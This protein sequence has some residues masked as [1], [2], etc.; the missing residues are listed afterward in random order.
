MMPRPKIL[1][2]NR[3]R[4]YRACDYCK[5][6]K[7][8]CDSKTPCGNC[9]KRGRDIE[10]T[11]PASTATGRGARG[12]AGRESR[13]T[14]PA[15]PLTLLSP[16]SD[17]RIWELPQG[18]VSSPCSVAGSCSGGQGSTSS[19][20]AIPPTTSRSNHSA[21]SIAADAEEV[22]R[23]VNQESPQEHFITTSSKEKENRSVY[24]GE[25]TSLSFLAF[26]RH[27][28]KPLIGATPFTDNEQKHLILDSDNRDTSG[29]EPRADPEEEASLFQ[30]YLEVTSGTLHLFSATEI[31]SLLAGVANNSSDCHVEDLAAMDAALA[32][33]AQARSGGR[34]DWELATTYFNRA[35]KVGFEDMLANPSLS[36]VRLF[37]LLAFFSLGA[38]RQNAASIYL[39]IASKSA[40][41]LGLHQPMSWKEPEKN[42]GPGF[43]MRVWHSLCILDVLISSVLGRPC[44]VPRATRHTIQSLPLH[45]DQPAFNVMLRGVA[46][47]DDICCAIN[48]GVMIDIATAQDLLRKLQAWCRDIP[49]SLRRF[50]HR[51][52]SPLSNA[53]RRN[54]FS[55]IYMSGMYYFAVI[56]V[57]RPFL[58]ENFMARIRHRPHAV[59]QANSDPAR[60]S[61]VQVCMSSASYMG[62]LS[63]QLLSIAVASA[64]PLGSLSLF[65]AW[66]FGAA[67]IL[68]F[69]ICAGET[70]TDLNE[71]F[72]GVLQLLTKIGEASPQ[73]KMYSETL[74]TFAESISIYQRLAAHKSRR[75]AEQLLEQVLVIDLDREPLWSSGLASDLPAPLPSWDY[76][77]AG[78]DFPMMEY[79][80]LPIPMNMDDVAMQIEEW[81]GLGLQFSDNFTVDFGTGIV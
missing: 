61:L 52:D 1:P 35:R 4:A 41:V 25:H 66:G 32:I 69:S 30:A 22:P 6:S 43:R 33:G 67:L 5:A 2:E 72:T 81:E 71:T 39:G 21:V 55:S 73:S 50:S 63:R 17:P 26:L 19:A 36:I 64:L 59:P 27:A 15:S 10:C 13:R 44:S 57:T 7:T 77:M 16:A 8:R 45:A 12:G 40:V 23:E 48:H 28:L 46:L 42:A 54:L 58:I 60:L 56:L 29:A 80:G 75:L 9:A 18:S 49:S 3:I 74:R 34:Y 11:Y 65:N 38:C 20:S 14:R 51:R 62:H 76:S 53:D 68:G 31:E 70:R 47:L 78:R 79:T 37:V 24:I